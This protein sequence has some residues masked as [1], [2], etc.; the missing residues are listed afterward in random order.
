M[1]CHM[2]SPSVKHPRMISIDAAA[3]R[4]HVSRRTVYRYAERGALT[5]RKDPLSSRV[6]V[7][8]ASVEAIQSGRVI[9]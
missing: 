9:L 5:L 1:L 4:L 2:T 8:L 6:G 3:R 7:E